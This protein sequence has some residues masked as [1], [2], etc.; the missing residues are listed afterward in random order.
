MGRRTLLLIAAL[1]IAALGSTMVFLYAQSADERAREGLQL[2]EVLVAQVDIPQGTTVAAAEETLAFVTE[3]LNAEAVADG[4]LSSV[5]AIRD[6]VALV[7]IYAGEQILP[8]K[9]GT[10]AQT[11]GQLPLTEGNLAM[12]ISLGDPQRVVNFVT[13][14]STVAIFITTNNPEDEEPTL[15]TR[16][17]LDRVRVIGVGDSTPV[18]QTTTTPEGEQTTQVPSAL[19]TFDVNQDQAQKIIFAQGQGELYLGL[20]DESSAVNAGQAPT[21]FGNLFN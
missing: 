11:T 6:Q 17:L 10:Q 8:Q 18:T 21:D 14:G 16:I 2:R 13:P 15:A 19:L 5:E 12:T 4:A 9:F 20:V 7:P 3:Q 1:L